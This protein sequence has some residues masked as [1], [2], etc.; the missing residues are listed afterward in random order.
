[1][2]KVGKKISY[3]LVSNG[4]LEGGVVDGVEIEAEEL[5]GL[6]FGLLREVGEVDVESG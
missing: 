1:M 6:V 4:G 5:A 3:S 2:R